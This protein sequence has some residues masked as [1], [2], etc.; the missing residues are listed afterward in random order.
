MSFTGYV[1][2]ETNLRTLTSR[3]RF[4]GMLT[5]PMTRRQTSNEVSVLYLS[6]REEKEN[7]SE[8]GRQNEGKTIGTI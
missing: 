4:R 5:V 6:K 7:K 3:A 1:H 2:V 8:S